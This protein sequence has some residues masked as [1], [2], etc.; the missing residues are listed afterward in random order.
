MLQAGRLG[1]LFSLAVTC[2]L[3]ASAALAQSPALTTVSEVRYRAYGRSMA[4][5]TN[6]ASIAAEQR[7][8]DDGTRG[9]VHQLRAP[10]ARTA[11]D[12]EN[13]AV[14]I[15][16]DGAT[17]RYQG[18]YQTWSDFLPGGAQD[19]FPGD[20]LAVNLP[21]QSAS[22]QA[23]VD[24][25]TIVV[26]DLA[27]DHSQY[28]IGF[29]D[30]TAEALSFEFESAKTAAALN[31]NPMTIAQVG[32]TTLPDL[33]SAAIAQVSSTT[34]TIDA[35]AA[36]LSGGGFEIR[37]SDAG[38]GPNNDQNLAGRFTAQTFTLPRLG[39]AQDYYLRQF[40]GSTPPKYS[41]YSAA[42]HVD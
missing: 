31:V 15:I 26:K 16:T 3:A 27:E 11:V 21:S 19:V 4:R 14:A 37:W 17:G 39:K 34:A 29:V 1:R 6:P 8:V 7:G 42:L 38:W 20:A 22:F 5:V 9:V 30:A 41:R 13:A 25:E 33:T 12:C 35:G 32:S 36:A 24:E 28:E 10:S 23:I 40:D 18:K 2:L